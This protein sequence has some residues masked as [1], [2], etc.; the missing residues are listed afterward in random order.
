PLAL[1][2]AVD[3]MR[4]TAAPFGMPSRYRPPEAE[5]QLPPYTGELQAIMSAL[6]RRDR[7]AAIDRATRWQLASPG[8]VAAILALGESLEARGA[9]A[10]AARAY[11]S[12]IDLFPGRVELLRT[13]GER[14]DRVAATLPG[15][16][17]WAIDAYRRALRER[18]DQVST[19]RLLAYA[20]LRDGRGDEAI[21]ILGAGLAR[22]TRP[23]VTEILA[24]DAGAIAAHLI[25]RDPAKRAKLT[26]RMRRGVADRPSLRIVLSWETDANDVDLHVRDRRGGHAFYSQRR[27]SS[28]GELLDDL[29]DGYGPEMFVVDSPTAF[30]Y[31]ASVHYFRRGP[32]GLGLST[33]QVIRHDGAGN[34]TVEDRPFVIQNDGA[35]IDLG[36]IASS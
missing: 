32:M 14:L 17:G 19:Y 20:L 21:D 26:R 30:P 5:P 7:D 12:L 23:S 2:I 13:A 11:G 6:A 28:G 3:R 33:V 29:T 4:S 24:A 31:H 1:E 9:G 10:L 35:M 36:A 18:P 15:A 34:L 8:D 27:L 22:S 25:A 16:R